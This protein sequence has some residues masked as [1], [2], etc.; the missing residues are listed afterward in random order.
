MVAVTHRD[1]DKFIGG[2][3]AQIDLFLIFGTDA[4]LISERTRA[5]LKKCGLNPSNPEQIIRLEGD[6][7]A[8]NPGQLFEEAH[9]M[10]LFAEKRAIVIRAGAKQIVAPLE[11]MLASPAADCKIMVQAG[12]LRKDAPLRVLATRARNAAAIECYPDQARDIENLIDAELK[13]AGLRIE[14]G[15]RSAL[16]G[17]LGDDR[18][19]TRSELEKLILYAH[20]TGQVGELDVMSA[21][22]DASAFALDNVVFAAFSGDLAF[23][24][25]LATPIYSTNSEV[26]ALLAAAARHA[27][28][29]NQIRIDVEAGS[30]IET[31]ID[32]GAGRNMF[33]ARRQQLVTQA[34]QWRRQSIATCIEELNQAT[35]DTRREPQLASAIAM[36]CLL[37]IARRYRM[38]RPYVR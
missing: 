34:N 5:V 4:G 29:L 18:L 36:Q 12:S 22:A 28:I 35:L 15:A 20:G 10:G 3:I 21:V 6:D 30:S 25:D 17:L 32:R 19:S 31:A 14:P 37:M 16:T 26:F 7:I 2:Q 13:A 24:G 11:T 23:L 27:Q 8:T 9:G 1:A 38:L 33:G